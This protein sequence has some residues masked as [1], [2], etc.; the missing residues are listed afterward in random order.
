M[1]PFRKTKPTPTQIM[2]TPRL[3]TLLATALLCAASPRNLPAVDVVVDISSFAPRSP[4]V[5]VR[6]I[7]LNVAIKQYEKVLMEVYEARLQSEFGTPDT[8]LSDEQKK[9]WQ[10]RAEKKLM[11]LEKTSHEL[12]LRIRE[13]VDEANQRARAIEEEKAREKAKQKAEPYLPKA[14]TRG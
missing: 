13:Y 7:E 1:I 5:V 10:I 6:Q 9:Q 12:R 8:A 4:D 14:E 2:K 11:Y 3:F